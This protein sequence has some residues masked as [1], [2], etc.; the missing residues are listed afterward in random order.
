MMAQEKVKQNLRFIEVLLIVVTVSL[1]FIPPVWANAGPPDTTVKVY[2]ER[3]NISVNEPVKFTL[4]CPAY[5]NSLNR[6]DVI[7][8]YGSTFSLS[9]L[10]PSYGC[11]FTEWFRGDLGGMTSCDLVGEE[12]NGEQFSLLNIQNPFS[13][14]W[15]KGMKTHTCEIHINISSGNI[16]AIKTQGMNITPVSVNRRVMETPQ[17]SEKPV[18][19][20]GI[21]DGFIC[22]LKNLLG[23]TC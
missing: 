2:F 12:F 13:C 19:T 1:I 16:T 21:F 10:C 6:G 14:T 8:K 22:F 18:V 17:V 20:E 7:H 4:N 3:N 11:F 9:L 15:G 5:N 23:G